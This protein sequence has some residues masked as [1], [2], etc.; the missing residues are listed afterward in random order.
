M[1]NLRRSGKNTI[2]YL[3][4]LGVT[5][6][7]VA[8]VF[9][10]AYIKIY[11][12][13]SLVLIRGIII[14][15]SIVG[16]I[17]L[18]VFA[19]EFVRYLGWGDPIWESVNDF[20]E[21]MIFCQLSCKKATGDY[22]PMELDHIECLLKGPSGEIVEYKG[23]LEE[24]HD[25]NGVV[26]L[27]RMEAEPGSYEVR[28]SATPG[29]QRLHEIARKKFSIPALSLETMPSNRKPTMNQTQRRG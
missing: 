29:G 26:A 20:A 18:L 23:S 13:W 6:T 22:H 27:F 19:W 21:G 28:W 14:G 9:V 2:L 5:S 15:V 10:D 25:P 7:I 11:I 3:L 12:P 4:F 17:Y 1:S 24:R 8:T 16:C